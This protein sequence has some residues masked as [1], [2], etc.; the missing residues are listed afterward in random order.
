MAECLKPINLYNEKT[1]K[2]QLV[3]CSKCY[4]CLQRKRAHWSFRIHQELKNSN[5]AKFITLT[6]DDDHLP[7]TE[8]GE[9]TLNKRHLQLF[10]KKLRKIDKSGDIPIRFFAT[11]EY[12]TLKDRPHYHLILFNLDINKKELVK[13]LSYAWT[14]HE[15]DGQIRGYIDIG[16]VSTESIHYVTKYLMDSPHQHNDT[17]AKPFNTM[18]R[19]PGIGSNYLINA[20][21]HRSNNQFYAMY[22][23]QK[24][25]LPRYYKDKIFLPGQKKQFGLDCE[26]KA[27]ELEDKLKDKYGEIGYYQY[28]EK[29]NELK[30][31]EFIKKSKKGKI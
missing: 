27:W 9:I 19:K 30:T 25:D 5:S 2:T 24:V 7:V 13:N 20:K 31:L 18:S 3:A 4:N 14:D 1:K 29:L 23:G 8:D 12:G 10:L 22:N 15:T 26:Q 17:R 21:M 6:Y 16:N 11:G 28:R